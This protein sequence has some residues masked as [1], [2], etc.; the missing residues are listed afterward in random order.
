[1]ATLT[2]SVPDD[3]LQRAMARL[4]GKGKADLKQYLL[5]VLDALTMEGEPIDKQ[6][7]AKLLQGLQSRPRELSDADWQAKLQ[8][9][10]ARHRKRKR[11]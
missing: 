6:T 9:Y 4:N 10:D 1:M 11:A 7:E 2:L 3:L 8:R 5:S